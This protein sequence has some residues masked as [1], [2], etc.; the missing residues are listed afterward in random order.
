[1][2]ATE[3]GLIWNARAS[4]TLTPRNFGSPMPRP[5]RE[6]CLPPHR[7][8]QPRGRPVMRWRQSFLAGTYASP[9]WSSLDDRVAL[10]ANLDIRHLVWAVPAK[11]VTKIGT[12]S[13]FHAL[14]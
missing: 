10:Y 8:G 4:I 14:P 7:L 1:M 5:L 6:C 11:F 13:F 3:S 12:H 9:A 2:F